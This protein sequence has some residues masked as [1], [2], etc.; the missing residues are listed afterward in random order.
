MPIPLLLHGRHAKGPVHYEPFGPWLVPWR[1]ASF[2]AEYAALATGVGLID[3][4]IY[5]TIDVQGADRVGFLHNLLSNDIKRLR[6]GQGCQAALLTANAKVLATCLVLAE[7]ASVRLLCHATTASLV[8]Q[9]LEQY[10]FSE[11][12]TIINHERRDAILALQGPQ[13]SGC[14]RRL[15]DEAPELPQPGDH[16]A[17][18]LAGHAIRIVSHTLIGQPG[19]LCS[20]PASEAQTVWTLL[21]E[22]GE[23]VG[24]RPVGWEALNTIRIEAGI[25]WFGIDFDSN[26]LLPETG[27]ETLLANDSK[28]CYVGQE[29]VARMQTYGSASKKLVGLLIEGAVVPVAGD[30]LMRGDDEVGMIT[31]A[32]DSPAL[33]HPIALGFVKRGS[34]EPG[35]TLEIL[36]GNVRHSA[37]VAV[38]PF[39]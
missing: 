14:L 31:S 1:I 29:I 19:W 4:S 3:Y 23:Q 32:C 11:D 27:L 22:R 30:R 15:L 10:H 33:Q 26:H 18:T 34:Y 9:T 39:V 12:V 13:T 28:G 6:P 8:T 16:A 20:I 2:E 17:A 24:V 7:E 37:A 38:R 5:S 35:T 36:H 25:P 21:Q